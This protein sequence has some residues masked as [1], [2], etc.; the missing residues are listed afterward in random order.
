MRIM[1]AKNN[2]DTLKITL[3]AFYKQYD[4]QQRIAYDPIELPHRYKKQPDI[5]TSGFIVSCLS[6]GRVALFKPVINRIL[7]IAGDSPYGF[8]LNFD[9]RRDAH[10]FEGIKYRMNTAEDITAFLYLLSVLLKKNGTLGR[11]FRDS[12]EK[13]DPNII[14]ALSKFVKAFY[15][16]DTSPLYGRNIRPFGLLQMLPSPDNGSTCKRAHMFLRW[17]VRGGDGVDFG[18]WTF[19]PADRLIMPLDTHIAR[20]ARHLGLTK[21]KATD[22]KT[23]IDITNNLKRFDPDDPVKYDFALCHLGI[24]GKCPS[25]K[26]PLS[27]LTCSLKDMCIYP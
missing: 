21:R 18:L 7:R 13:D 20:I 17:M 3:D 9:I 4:L 12:F 22:I 10:L 25:K 15:S 26:S 27:C 24:S 5:E 16:E 11:F 1:Q 6:Y 2:F 14:N 8:F 23:A 19:I